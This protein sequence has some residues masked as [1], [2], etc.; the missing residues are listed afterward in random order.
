[1]S[2]C[3]LIYLLLFFLF[4]IVVIDIVI[5]IVV[6]IVVVLARPVW[7]WPVSR[8]ALAR[9]L[10]G[11]GPCPSAGAT[12]VRRGRTGPS[13]APSP[14]PPL[15][16]T[17]AARTRAC[18]PHFHLPLPQLHPSSARDPPCWSQLMYGPFSI[19]PSCPLIST[20]HCNLITAPVYCI[21]LYMTFILHCF[22]PYFTPSIQ[23]FVFSC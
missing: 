4:V 10:S 13:R 20:N 16:A 12:R 11:P 21:S 8:L 22:L 18:T 23:F 7:P 6:V 1:M 5:D 9:V 19:P 2:D 15:A 3:L 14:P 17:T